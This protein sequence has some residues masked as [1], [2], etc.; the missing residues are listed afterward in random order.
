MKVGASVIFD[1]DSTNKI[2]PVYQ[3]NS[4]LNSNPD[5]DYG[6][7]VTLKEKIESGVSITQFIY[8]FT[9]SGVYVFT[10]N[11]AANA[12]NEKYVVF[13]I[14]PENGRCANEDAFIQPTTE[15]TLLLSGAYQ[16]K[17][18]VYDPDWIF[19][20]LVVVAFVV[21]VLIVLL[22]IYCF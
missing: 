1:C 6:E 19:I 18:V 7:F 17:N 8:T 3:R 15:K 22:I 14:Q 10:F 13:G 4:L 11:N 20:S 5:F 9:T 16:N 21:L 12:D 2:Y